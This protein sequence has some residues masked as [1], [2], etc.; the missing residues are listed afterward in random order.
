ME[1]LQIEKIAER[2]INEFQRRLS[3]EDIPLICSII[4]NSLNNCNVAIPKKLNPRSSLFE[5][6]QDS[7]VYTAKIDNDTLTAFQELRKKPKE[8]IR[9]TLTALIQFY[10]NHDQLN[11][12]LTHDVLASRQSYIKYTNQLAHNLIHAQQD[13]TQ[14]KVEFDGL[15]S[16]LGIFCRKGSADSTLNKTFLGSIVAALHAYHSVEISTADIPM[17]Y[18]GNRA[19]LKYQLKQQLNKQP[20]MYWSAESVKI[21]I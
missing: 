21:F 10:S 12:I 16:R 1:Q 7:K 3:K 4:Q 20:Q 9:K 18:L 19:A 11:L 8:D 15:T 6:C 13:Y 5:T 17:S 2:L 14:I